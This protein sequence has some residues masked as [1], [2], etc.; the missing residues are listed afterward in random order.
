MIR[1][2]HRLEIWHSQMFFLGEFV[3]NRIYFRNVNPEG[4]EYGARAQNNCYAKP[5][6]DFRK[7]RFLQQV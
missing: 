2:G 5:P 4:G 7:V 6:R 3:Q 1:E